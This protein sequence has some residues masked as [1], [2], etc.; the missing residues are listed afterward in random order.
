VQIDLEIAPG[1]PQVPLDVKRLKQAFLNLLSNAIDA[2]PE[3]GRLSLTVKEEQGGVAVTIAD[4]GEGIAS[5]R[6]PLIFEPF[7]TSKGKGTGLGLSITHNIVS[8]H[9]GRVQVAS[10]EG[11]GAAFTIWLPCQ[12]PYPDGH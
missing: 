6:L 1:L 4:T 10:Q 8:D 12:S 2:M 11:E 9:G 5:D 3:G 7:Y